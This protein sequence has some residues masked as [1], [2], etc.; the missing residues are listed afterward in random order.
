MVHGWCDQV[1]QA[2]A[3]SIRTDLRYGSRNDTYTTGLLSG[4]CVYALH[5]YLPRGWR[6][7]TA[8]LAEMGAG[9]LQWGA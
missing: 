2:L 1:R 9:I 6:H 8:L 7:D 3:P 5:T 4:G